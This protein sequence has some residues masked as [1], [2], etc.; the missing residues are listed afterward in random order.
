MVG[1]MSEIIAHRGPDDHGIWNDDRSVL[2]HRRLSIL[3][4]SPAGH[5]PMQ[6][7]D[8]HLQIIFNGEIYNY[9][10]LRTELIRLG[11]SFRTGTDTEVILSA[12][13][14]WGDE[15]QGRFNGM[16]AFVIWDTV[17]KTAFASRDRFGKK[18]FYYVVI[19]DRVYFSSEIKALLEVPG[20]GSELQVSNVA[21]FCAERLIDHTEDTFFS[22]VRQ[23]PAAHCFRWDGNGM[24][25][26]RY[27]DLE[28]ASQ[29]LACEIRSEEIEMLGEAFNDAVRLR[30]RSDV[31]VGSLLSGGIDSSLVT[32]VSRGQL[33]LDRPFHI[34]STLTSPPNEEGRGIDLVLE[35][36]GFVPHFHT[37]DAASFWEDLPQVIYHQEEPFGD[38]SMVAHFQLMREARHAGVPVLLSGQGGDEVFAGY[39]S[40]LWIWLGDLF[41]RRRI[42]EGLEALRSVSKHQRIAWWNI[43]YHSLPGSVA[44]PVRH[45][46]GRNRLNWVHSDFLQYFNRDDFAAGAGDRL[47]EYQKGCMRRWTLPGFLHYEDRNSMAFGVETR[48]PFLDYRL[49]EKVLSFGSGLKL[50]QGVTK[51]IL[52]EIGKGIV[53]EAILERKEKQGYPAPLGSWLRESDSRVREIANSH[54]ARRCPILNQKIWVRLVEDYLDH[55]SEDL[56]PVWRGLVIVLWYSR[57]FS[58]RSHKIPS[59]VHP[60]A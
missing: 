4:L 44:H 33:S 12:Y 47:N 29:P 25:V 15:C 43:L 26:K 8:G 21:A 13:Q 7:S 19:G 30:L 57:F 28:P 38:A 45:H 10:E 60:I 5:Q 31:P 56:D 11:H 27:W 17:A 18:P 52:R 40:Y 48:L 36:G 59:P 55:R 32:C 2:A 1:H 41:R 16:W 53:P 49:A 24:R 3:D 37:P 42:V 22:G 35:R 9:L 54:E 6:S 20:V 23:L 39:G 34:F 51:W 58:G 46:I 14:Q 50:Q